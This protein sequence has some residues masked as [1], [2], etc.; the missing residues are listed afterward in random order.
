[1]HKSESMV[2][3]GTNGR[4]QTN[5]CLAIYKHFNHNLLAMLGLPREKK[6]KLNHGMGGILEG[7]WISFH[8]SP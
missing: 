6:F 2:K 7:L 5:C 8:G 4:G 3:L 1:M